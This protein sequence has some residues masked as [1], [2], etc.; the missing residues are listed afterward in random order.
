MEDLRSLCRSVCKLN[1]Q[2]TEK[3]GIKH[4]LT[5]AYHPLANGLD[6]RYNQTLVNS[7]ANFAQDKRE[8]WDENVCEVVYSYNTAVQESTKHTP[9]ESMFGRMAILPVD[10]SAAGNYDPDDMIK[11]FDEAKEPDEE[12]SKAKRQKMANWTTFG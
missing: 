10:I 1:Q 5:T 4:Q 2:L 9:F 8:T 12:E 7:L 11:Q 3:F 6:E